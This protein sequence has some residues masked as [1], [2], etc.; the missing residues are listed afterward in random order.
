MKRT[1]LFAV[2]CLALFLL[3][4]LFRYQPPNRPVTAR[5][6]L[7]EQS[8]QATASLTSL[9]KGSPVSPDAGPRRAE[10]ST[11]RPTKQTSAAVLPPPGA[12]LDRVVQH[13][14]AEVFAEEALRTFPLH[15]A[16]AFDPLSADPYGPSPGE[17]WIRIKADNSREMKHIMDEVA[18][19]Y[20]DLSGTAEPVTVIHWVGNRPYSRFEYGLDR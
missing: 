3:A 5:S 14:I 13:E 17:L 16:R 18:A 6:G 8:S 20:R 11:T 1:L 19:L 4:A 10:Q 15:T 9:A 2:G 7:E 12:D